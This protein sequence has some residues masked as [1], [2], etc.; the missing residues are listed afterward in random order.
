MTTTSRITERWNTIANHLSRLTESRPKSWWFWRARGHVRMRAGH[1]DQA[2]AD[3][4]KAIE[5]QPDDGWSWLG[6]G[7]ARKNRGQKQPA[8]ADLTRSVALEPNVPSAW[9]MR[10]EILGS[11]IRWDEAAEA[12]DR[13]SALGGDPGAIPWY[14][15]TILRLYTGDH[16]GYRRACQAMMDRFGT[17]TDPFVASLAAH[18]CS[19]GAD[20]GVDFGRVVEPGR[21]GRPRQTT[22]RLVDLYPGSGPPPRRAPRRGHLQVRPGRPRRPVLDRHTADRRGALTDRASPLDPAGEERSVAAGRSSPT[23]VGSGFKHTPESDPQN[24]R[25]LAVSGRGLAARPRARRRQDT[26]KKR[27]L[28][29]KMTDTI[30]RRSRSI[31]GDDRHLPDGANGPIIVVR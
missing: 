3:Y 18:A 1:P 31:D 11:L 23:H 5:V 29:R 21:A 6:R 19:L 25:R 4:G 8:L 15:H 14:Y 26:H 16:P 10:G 24:E 30:L 7:L 13:W 9:A 27:R 22:R 17:T 28:S 12:Y 2:E 20:S